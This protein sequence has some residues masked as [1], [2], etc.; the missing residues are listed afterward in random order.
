MTAPAYRTDPAS[1]PCGAPGTGS[2]GGW[3][4]LRLER[5]GERAD[6]VVPVAV[7]VDGEHGVAVAGAVCV[8]ERAVDGTAHP[9]HD[10]TAGQRDRGHAQAVRGVRDPADSG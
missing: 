8:G 7:D 4:E 2:A 6:R 3:A 10:L 1:S 5:L 9:P